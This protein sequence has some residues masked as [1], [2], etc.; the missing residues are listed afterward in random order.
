MRPKKGTPTSRREATASRQDAAASRQKT[1]SPGVQTTNLGLALQ[2]LGRL[3]EAETALQRAVD[4]D[5]SSFDFMYALADHYVKRGELRKALPLAERIVSANP[6]NTLGR[7]LK[8][9]IV[10][11]LGSEIRN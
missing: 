5:P 3:T 4:L 7:D 9:H 11:A 10:E 1:V 8:A 2:H 6:E